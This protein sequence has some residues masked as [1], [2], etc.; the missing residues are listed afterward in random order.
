MDSAA[1]TGRVPRDPEEIVGRALEVAGAALDDLVRFLGDGGTVEDLRQAWNRLLQREGE[2]DLLTG[3]PLSA[4]GR[5][6]SELLMAALVAVAAGEDAPASPARS[7]AGLDEPRVVAGP[8]L[9]GEAVHDQ[10][11]VVAARDALAG[12]QAEIARLEPQL[13]RAKVRFGNA[14]RRLY[15]AG[16][17][18]TSIAQAMGMSEEAV[19]RVVWAPATDDYQ[20]VLACNFCTSHGRRL[21]AGPGVY[22]CSE[23]VEAAQAVGAGSR[24]D[25]EKLLREPADEESRCSFCGKH[26]RQV[27]FVVAAGAT[28]I[29]DECLDLC[30][31]I[32]AEEIGG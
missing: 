21:I 25:D 30:A 4:T 31:E 22:I 19:E 6:A 5:I 28:R 14:I 8:A 9:L 26:R 18:V 3:E 20:P 27:R 7:R 16:A 12:A 24:Q 11:L 17:P 10:D 32:L 23:C 15:Q 13:N 1:T 29:C 2:G